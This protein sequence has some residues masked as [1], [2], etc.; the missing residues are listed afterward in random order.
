[1]KQRQKNRSIT[2]LKLA[3]E[4]ANF[5]NKDVITLKNK[6]DRFQILNWELE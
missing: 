1:L 5:S 2:L 6:N 3:K 4:E